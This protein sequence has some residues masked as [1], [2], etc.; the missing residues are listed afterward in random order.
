MNKKDNITYQKNLLDYISAEDYKNFLV[1]HFENA[2]TQ[3]DLE[4]LT[5]KKYEMYNAD[6]IVIAPK[7][8]N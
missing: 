3:K 6:V 2:E 7:D 5:G 1:Q 8:W 4:T